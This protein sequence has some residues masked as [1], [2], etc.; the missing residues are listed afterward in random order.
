MAQ[1]QPP[2]QQGG[3]GGGGSESNDFL[4]LIVAIVL[5]IGFAWYFWQQYI[6][7]GLLIV[8]YYELSA[9]KFVING[10]NF[11]ASSVD[12]PS[13]GLSRITQWQNYIL[14]KPG[15]VGFQTLVDASNVMG[16]YLRYPA[17]LILAVLA[18]VI[19]KRHVSSQFN[20]KFTMERL[21]TLEQENWPQI[22]PIIKL[23]LLKDD[24]N[25]GPWAMAQTPI[26]FCK[27]YDLIDPE[28]EE[29][30]KIAGLKK[31]AAHRVFALQL[32]RPFISLE[33]LPVHMQ[34][35][36]AIFAARA[37][38]ETEPSTD[39]LRQI[40]SSSNTGKLDF[41]G[42]RAMLQKNCQIKAV[43]R[44]VGRHAYVF[45]VMA[46]MLELARTDGVLAAAEF[47]WLKPLDRKLWYILD[48]VGRQ[49]AVC[50]VAGIFA[51]WKAEKELGRPLK[52]PMVDEAV[53]ALDVGLKDIIYQPEED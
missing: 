37:N 53:K 17:V 11:V 18:Y 10:W 46:S 1:Q 50:E 23:D 49:T 27:K 33:K 48:S 24:I 12:L 26:Q 31:G 36:F 32:G 45:G 40:A 14:S 4:W 20:K 3:G 25:K 44:A 30:Q 34:A 5:A 9:I 28:R 15:N 22:T 8:R 13:I 35:L 47:I 41:S 52:V 16:D 42:Y 51:H 38:H 6:T 43:G 29:G 21:R 39:L 2:P 19:Y 7:Q